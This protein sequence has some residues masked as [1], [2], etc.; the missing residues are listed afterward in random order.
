M[1][2]SET[3]SRRVL[4]M[5]GSVGLGVVLTAGLASCTST[6]PSGVVTGSF[7]AVGGPVGAAPT[8]LAGTITFKSPEETFT[9][10][11]GPSGRFTV[12]APTGSYQLTGRSASF[13]GPRCLGGDVVVAAG[14]T[15][16]AQVICER[17]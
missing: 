17:S 14:R 15:S 3:F 1:S 7:L 13:G 11:S 16:H 9:A 10:R 5:L 6:A 2:A 4:A 12:D 8:P